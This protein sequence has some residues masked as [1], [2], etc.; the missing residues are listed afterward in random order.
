VRTKFKALGANVCRVRK[1]LKKYGVYFT[2]R[3][4]VLNFHK[5]YWYWS[6]GRPFHRTALAV[7][8]IRGEE[9]VETKY[10]RPKWRVYSK[11][12]TIRRLRQRKA[13]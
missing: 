10:I 13:A 2:A 7:T 6:F 8:D 5:Y 4:I 11:Q 9:S 12:I 1:Y 3:G